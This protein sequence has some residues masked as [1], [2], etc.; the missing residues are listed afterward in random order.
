MQPL[1]YRYVMYLYMPDIIRSTI[2]PD[3][4]ILRLKF[5]KERLLATN[6]TDIIFAE[7]HGHF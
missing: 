7:T 5:V 6:M 4:I 2:L 1:K 3:D